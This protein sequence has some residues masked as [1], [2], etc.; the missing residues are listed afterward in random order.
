[1]GAQK[2]VEV[3]GGEAVTVE[4]DGRQ[5]AYLER[6]SSQ[7]RSATGA[8]LSAPAVIRAL[9]EALS[10]AAAVNPAAIRSEDDLKG[11]FYRRFTQ[12]EDPR[13]DRDRM[14]A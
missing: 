1:M 8:Q 13:H 7:I 4:L 2:T 5:L 9:V 6:L 3:R 10:E 12:Q 11:L 14:R